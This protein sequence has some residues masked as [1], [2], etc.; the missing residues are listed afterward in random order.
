MLFAKIVGSGYLCGEK[1]IT[2][3][4]DGNARIWDV[5]S[6][7][8]LQSWALYA[9]NAHSHF[10]IPFQALNEKNFATIGDDGNIRVWNVDSGKEVQKLQGDVS[11]PTFVIFSSDG[12]KMIT[13]DR[14]AIQFRDVESGKLLQMLEKT[15]VHRMV[16][17]PDGRRIAIAFGKPSDLITQIFD[18][19]SGLMMYV[20][21]GWS[22]LKHAQNSFPLGFA[23]NGK[24][25]V[26]SG[27]DGSVQIIDVD[28]GK[29]LH[30]LT[31]PE[32]HKLITF[33]RTNPPRP[34][35][36]SSVSFSP[37]GKKVA[38]GGNYGYA[39]VWILEE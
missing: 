10:S 28:S 26:I 37:N 12:K 38:V 35:T 6:G 14:Y 1:I 22:S 34:T 7:K 11:H 20:P 39:V 33:E 19:D 29:E 31:L 24:Q 23:P 3:C 5:K 9:D 30:K 2:A 15:S 4:Q 21:Q 25:L 18:V 36:A 27:G 13:R 8:E 16:A 32:L 17:S